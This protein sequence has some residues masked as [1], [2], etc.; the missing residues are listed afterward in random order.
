[1]KRKFQFG[2]YS[3]KQ[4]PVYKEYS[5]IKKEHDFHPEEHYVVPWELTDDSEKYIDKV[6]AWE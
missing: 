4:Y 3:E 6:K 5:P 2:S 1:M